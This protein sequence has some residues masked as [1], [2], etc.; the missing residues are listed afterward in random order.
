[1]AAHEL[2]L[3]V[4]IIIR[5][6]STDVWARISNYGSTAAGTID[7]FRRS[8]LCG[9]DAAREKALAGKFALSGLGCEL[10]GFNGGED[11]LALCASYTK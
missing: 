10:G 1:L 11:N 5:H 8:R 3:R 7:R 6:A 4:R 2:L 9:T